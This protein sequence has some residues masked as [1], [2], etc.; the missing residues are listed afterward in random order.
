MEITMTSAV[1]G[2]TRTLDLP[3]TQEQ[4]D[5]WKAGEYIQVAMSNLTADQ[6]EFMM[7]GIT[8]GEITQAKIESVSAV[9]SPDGKSKTIHKKI[10]QRP[11]CMYCSSLNKKNAIKKF[12]GMYERLIKSGNIIREVINDDPG[13]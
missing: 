12:A 1:S 4:I 7:T 6:R 9:L 2:K 3:V 10:I 13:K 5:A 11:Q 8:A